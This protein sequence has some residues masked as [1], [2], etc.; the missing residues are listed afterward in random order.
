MNDKNS[1]D[2]PNPIV[3]L[4]YLGTNSVILYDGEKSLLIDP[5]FTRP[6]LLSLTGKVSS[7][8]DKVVQ[9]IQQAGFEHLDAVF[10]THAHYD[11]AMDA[12]AAVARMGG[13][14]YGSQSSASIGLGWGM[15][16][17][18]VQ[19]LGEK[20]VVT[21]GDFQCSMLPGKH[22][23]FPFGLGKWIDEGGL[24]T[25]PLR[26]PCHISD[27]RAGNVSVLII[28]HPGGSTLVV[29]SAGFNLGAYMDIEV[30][31]VV[32]GIGGLGLKTRAYQDAFFKTCVL[33]TGARNVFISHWDNFTRPLDKPLR[34]LY[35]SMR[36]LKRFQKL[37]E[38]HGPI[39]VRLLQT[40][41]AVNILQ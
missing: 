14:L 17:G 33:D 32:L 23:P 31:S 9:T 12:P 35:G 1:L 29:G 8:E 21:I 15:S 7:D 10:L 13:V 26:Q 11:H 19:I 28:D 37:A 20:E 41:E 5:H 24:I 16:S 4:K 36:V 3:R 34:P 18:Q 22:L 25:E 40:W 2:Y 27:F 30:D 6:S 38:E 39:T